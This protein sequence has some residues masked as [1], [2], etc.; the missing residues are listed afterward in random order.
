MAGAADPM[1]S[2]PAGTTFAPYSVLRNVSDAP[3]S[4]MPTL[5]WMAAGAPQSAQLTPVSIQPHQTLGLDVMSLLA[6]A[7]LVSATKTFNGSFNLVFAANI[8]TGALL[9]AAGSVD[10]TSTY[11]FEVIPRGV[12]EG[13][14]KSLQYWSTGNGDDTMVT[15]WNPADEGQDFVVTLFFGL[16]DGTRGHY[17]WPLHLEARATRTFNVSQVIESQIPDSEGNII[18]A[19]VHEGSLKIAG[20]QAAHQPILIAVD[21]GTYNVRKAT[22]GPN[23]I[24]CD[25]FVQVTAAPDSFFMLM[26]QT[27]QFYFTGTWS[28]GTEDDGLSGSW[29]SSATSVATVDANSGL[30]TAVGAGPVTIYF[31][32]GSEPLGVGYICGTNGVCPTG[33]FTAGAGGSVGDPTPVVQSL[34]PGIWNAGT[35]PTVTITGSY[36]GTN[37]ALGITGTSIHY[38]QPSN[39]MDNGQPNG[40]SFTTNV[41]IDPNAPNETATI[42]V[43]SRGL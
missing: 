17:L 5:W 11:V 42:T 26:G 23:C 30:A 21:S 2:F 1:M 43:T 37:P 7:G 39:I 16:P 24:T 40:A 35:A 6:Q 29:Y 28:D 31:T 4:V 33:D 13:G 20:G 34:S 25:G 3:L 36:F 15:M 10:Q 27:T 8:K 19:V 41:T 14:S 22:C 12:A 18:P 38:S 9:L 32:P